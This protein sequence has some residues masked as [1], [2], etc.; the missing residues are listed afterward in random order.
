MVD[1]GE[2]EVLPL[3]G[4]LPFHPPEAVQAVAPALD[5]LRVEDWP[6]AVA[7][8]VA[9]IKTV[10]AL[11]VAI[12]TVALLLTIPP[13]PVQDSVYVVAAEGESKSLP[14]SAL[15][16]FQPPDAVQVVAFLADHVSVEDWP[17]TIE[18][19]LAESV[20]VGTSATNS[21]PTLFWVV[22]GSRPPESDA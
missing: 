16:P 15:A 11:T 14:L 19:G 18:V 22:V 20:T 21:D 17:L 3:I 5:Q 4:R 10:G 1:A 9:V 7:A 2:T 6:A 13:G 8:G 12:L